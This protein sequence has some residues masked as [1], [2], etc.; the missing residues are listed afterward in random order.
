[1]HYS[2]GQPMNMHCLNIYKGIV[3]NF[4]SLQCIKADNNN[5]CPNIQLFWALGPRTR[6]H[7]ASIPWKKWRSE[8]R[9]WSPYWKFQGADWSPGSVRSAGCCVRNLRSLWYAMLWARVGNL[10]KIVLRA[11]ITNARPMTCGCGRKK[12]KSAPFQGE[13]REAKE[14][15]YSSFSTKY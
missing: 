11:N 5:Q 15:K 1:M 4:T 9:R 13:K 2:L 14:N 6:L 3:L 10:Y 7:V 12:G 8:S